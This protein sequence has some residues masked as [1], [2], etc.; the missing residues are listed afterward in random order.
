M[1]T[2]GETEVWKEFIC[3]AERGRMDI[4]IRDLQRKDFNKAIDF[5]IQGMHF[6]WYLD[7]K[8]ML[9]LYGR[10]FWYS[11]T[12]RATQMIAAYAGNTLAGV[13]LADMRGEKRKYHSFWKAWYVRIFNFLQKTFFKGSVGAYDETNREMLGEYTSSN[14]PDGEIIFLA[15]N[16]DVK[17]KG[18]GTLLLSELETREKG[19]MVYLYTDNACSYQFYE[20]RGFH[21]AAERKIM[22]DF[23]KKKVPLVCLLYSKV[24]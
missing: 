13:L 7:S 21:K 23:G 24:L 6:D 16:P 19:K 12:N 1:I 3:V 18:I 10:Y 4:E 22:L 5:A 11:E 8:F 17:I 15:A 9:N 2:D 14:E 20:H